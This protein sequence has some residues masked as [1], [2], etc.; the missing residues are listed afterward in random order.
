MSVYTISLFLHV[1][2][3]LG[4]FAALG[5]EWAGL[6]NLRRATETSQVREWIGLLAAPRVVGGPAALITLVSG[7]YMSATRWGPQ[8]WIVV[9]LAGMV[10]IAVL[11]ATISGRRVGAIAGALPESVGPI[12]KSLAQQ[13]HDPAL[14]LGLRVRTALGLGIV[15]LMSTRPGWG[16]A[17]AVMGL[18]VVAGAA[19][20][21]PARGAARGHTQMAGNER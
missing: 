9:G 18:A 8:G 3:A 21:L 4:I 11:G 5:L 1:V 12:S 14:I 19:A 16:G 6:S 20:A 2:G 7:I 15:F 13:L 10:V 17:L